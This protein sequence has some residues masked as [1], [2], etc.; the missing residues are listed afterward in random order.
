MENETCVECPLGA[1][2][3]VQGQTECISCGKNLTT[4]SNG[5]VEE[6]DCIGNVS[7]HSL[8]LLYSRLYKE[9]TQRDH[10]AIA[11]RLRET[12]EVLLITDPLHP[13]HFS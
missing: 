9:D 5:T 3:P 4:A 13:E 11:V 6:S 10:V 2:Q 8:L 7:I 12:V 1:Y